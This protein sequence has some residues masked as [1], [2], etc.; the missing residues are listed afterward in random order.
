MKKIVQ[1]YHKFFEQYFEKPS[2]YQELLE[3]QKPNT[4]FI[5]CC[6][7]RVDPALIV[8]V[9]PGEI[10]VERNVA[11]VIPHRADGPNSILIA[12]EVALC[13]FEVED[14][15]VLGHQRCAGVEMLASNA[16]HT[17]GDVP[18]EYSHREQDLQKILSKPYN[19][20]T[21]SEFEKLNILL[22][23]QNLMSH[24]IVADRVNLKKTTVHG[25]YLSLQTGKLE[26][27]CMSC[28][29]FTTLNSQC[30][31]KQVV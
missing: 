20:T 3:Q 5:A 13:R 23:C 4:M 15:V 7:S 30:C 26:T 12:L 6:D 19:Q 22:S 17:F 10:F 27:L 25:W 9:Q 31:G 24:S 28:F 14:I 8:C 29:K 18:V 16:L 2:V 21:A 1:G 11:N